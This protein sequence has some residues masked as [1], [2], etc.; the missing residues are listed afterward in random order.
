[1]TLFRHPRLQRSTKEST[2]SSHLYIS[3]FGR[4]GHNSQILR[5]LRRSLGGG[6]GGS[7][8]QNAGQRSLL[9]VSI[10]TSQLSTHC[11]LASVSKKSSPK[12]WTRIFRI[13]LQP[14]GKGSISLL[15]IMRAF[16][17]RTNRTK[18]AA[19]TKVDFMLAGWCCG[20]ENCWDEGFYSDF[21][22]QY[23]LVF[24]F[25]G[26]KSWS[27]ISALIGCSRFHFESSNFAMML[28]DPKLWNGISAN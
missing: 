4:F 15:S 5:D 13:D 12:P 2:A 11:L 18:S 19:Q 7:S 3:S 21:D 17:D 20:V 6:R 14:G 25:W 16:T 10:P 23:K 28:D 24:C 1:M 27:C 26:K 9:K 22:H 8:A